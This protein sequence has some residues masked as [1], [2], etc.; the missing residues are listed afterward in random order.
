[1]V[2]HESTQPRSPEMNG[3]AERLNRI[4]MERVRVVMEAQDIPETW[5]P[6]LSS[7]LPT[8]EIDAQQLKRRRHGS[9]SITNDLGGGMSAFW[10]ARPMSEIHN[11]TVSLLPALTNAF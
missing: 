5:S 3:K 1:M 2:E 8:S 10:V 7:Q 11:L 4:I 9:S 6:K